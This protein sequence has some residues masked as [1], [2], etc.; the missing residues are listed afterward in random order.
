MEECD[1]DQEEKWAI[2]NI[3]KISNKMA[4]DK[5]GFPMVIHI[6]IYLLGINVIDKKTPYIELDPIKDNVGGYW[7]KWGNVDVIIGLRNHIFP[8]NVLY[9]M[10]I[11]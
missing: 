2:L 10:R 6:V 9:D 8:N 11:R 1:L 5:I 7:D 4:K 3:Q